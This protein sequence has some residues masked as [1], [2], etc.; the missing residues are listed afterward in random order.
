MKT[1]KFN[2]NDLE[3]EYIFSDVYHGIK[4][5]YE[6]TIDKNGED[7]TLSIPATDLAII[8]QK[9]EELCI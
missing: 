5:Y 4:N 9:I 2:H 1:G 6:Y 7:V 8:E 3:I